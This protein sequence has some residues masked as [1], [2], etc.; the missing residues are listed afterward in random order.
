MSNAMAAG[1]LTLHSHATPPQAVREKAYGKTIIVGEHAVVYGSRA[2]AMPVFSVQMHVDLIPRPSP[3]TSSESPSI[4]VTL[5]GRSLTTH[6]RGVVD[7][8]FACMGL[9]PFD[10]DLDGHSSVL[11][12]AG[13][14]SSAS[15]CVVVLR[16]LAKSTGMSI[17]RRDLAAMANQL[18][19][20]FHGN[21]SGLDT[22]VVA[23]E[24]VITFQRGQSPAP[25]TIKSPQGGSWYFAVL[26][27]GVRSSTLD[28]VQKAAPYFRGHDGDSRLARFD[29]LSASV[30]CGLA[31]GDVKAVAQAMDEVG[32]H[33]QAAGIV[34]PPL[35]DT[36]R[37]ACESGA[38]AAK[39]TG[40]GGGG[41]VLALLDP[42]E[43]SAQLTSLK[44]RLG[45][46][47][48][49]DVELT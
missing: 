38:L 12:G 31:C 42:M 6:L 22:A 9:E 29:D 27:S 43:A 49:F 44:S 48:V 18:E 32:S 13:L 24:E 10:L 1:D 41:C 2:V 34:S 30:A 40:A 23:W 5:G 25:V 26:D 35:E 7:E 21:P 19:K 33:L 46:H 4:R 47:R 14:G 16:A 39:V 37:I 20:R 8:A 11:V 36:I 45:A 15:L 3:H 28:M 17:D